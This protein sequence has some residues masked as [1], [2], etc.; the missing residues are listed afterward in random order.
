MQ[1]HRAG[2]SSNEGQL[3]GHLPGQAR[4]PG[5]RGQGRGPPPAGAGG[6]RWA[7]TRY[8][9]R[10]CSPSR[11]LRRNQ[12]SAN[13]RGHTAQR[14]LSPTKPD[15]KVPLKLDSKGARGLLG[16]TWGPW[17]RGSLG[18]HQQLFRIGNGSRQRCGHRMRSLWRGRRGQPRHPGKHAGGQAGP[19]P[20]GPG[21][22]A[23]PRPAEGCILG[24]GDTGA[25]V[26]FKGAERQNFWHPLGAPEASKHFQ[27]LTHPTG[28]VLTARRSRGQGWLTDARG[29]AGS[30]DGWR[31]P[32]PLSA[33]PLAIQM[34]G[35]ST[36][37]TRNL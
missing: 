33:W 28:K 14:L 27:A 29:T 1:W 35:S 3:T 5:G 36:F 7:A 23:L 12:V 34:S 16:E 32:G 24:A 17:F 26:A 15:S 11:A 2:G 22:P 37:P 8:W 10:T 30:L 31:S 19:R 25:S 20:R 21:G 13:A 4:A 9:A 18:P 6:P